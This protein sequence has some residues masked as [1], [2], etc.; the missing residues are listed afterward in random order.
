MAGQTGCPSARIMQVT[1]KP[2]GCGCTCGRGRSARWARSGRGRKRC[3][4]GRDLSTALPPH[5][6]LLIIEERVLLSTQLCL[7]LQE[8]H[9]CSYLLN[10]GKRQGIVRLQSGH[11][12]LRQGP[13]C[14]VSNELPTRAPSAD[15]PSRGAK[16]KMRLP[17]LPSDKDCPLQSCIWCPGQANVTSAYAEWGLGFNNCTVPLADPEKQRLADRPAH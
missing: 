7:F 14:A 9:S 11:Q 5:L 8:P 3:C 10:A 17:K 12:T 4:R 2:W 6:A 16:L 1:C 13:G 15:H